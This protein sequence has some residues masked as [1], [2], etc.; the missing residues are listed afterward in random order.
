MRYKLL[1]LFIFISCLCVQ[2][3]EKITGVQILT[4]GGKRADSVFISLLRGPDTRV[5]FIPTAASSLRS[6]AG[7]IWTPGE[8]ENKKEFTSELLKR[9]KLNAI[10]IL[11]TRDPKEANTEEFTRALRNADAV[12]ISSG[13]AGRFMA[14][15]K[16]T[17][18]EKELSRLLER[19]G[20]IGGESAGAIVQGQYTIRGNPDKPVLM[21]KGSEAGLGLLKHIAVNPHLTAQKR[22]NELVTIIDQYPELTGI[23][24]DDDTGLLISNGIAEV[25]GAGRVAIY[26]NKKHASGW[27]YWLK[28]GEKFDVVKL[29]QVSK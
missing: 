4:S 6:D 7:V 27:Y 29:K 24:I 8:E 19:G 20:I 14:A 15:Y 25:F 13:N 18:T 5:V 3:Q 1:L 17:L 11:H 23:G 12:W 26:D 21:A 9:F 16:G 28:P 10:T 2:A 22:E